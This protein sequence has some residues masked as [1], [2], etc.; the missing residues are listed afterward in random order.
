ME[1]ARSNYLGK[2]ISGMGSNQ[3]K[4]ITGIR[5]CGK[6]YLLNTIFKRHLLEIG[7]PEDHIMQMDFDGFRNKAYRNP[8]RFLAFV[9]ERVS[10]S[11]KYYLLLDEVQLLDDFAEVLNDL[12]RMDSV[13][14]YVT[15]SNA[16]LL[17]K[18][19]VTEFR[20]RGM[21]IPLRPLSFSEFMEGYDG[22]RRDGYDEYSMY[23]GLP[24]VAKLTDTKAKADYL[25]GIYDETYIRDIVERNDLRSAGDLS[26]VVDVLCSNIGCITNPTK[27]SN[28][29]KSEKKSPLSRPTIDAY[30]GYL[31]D[32]FLFE[33]AMRYDVKGRKYIGAGAK[34]Y[35]TDLGLRNARMNFRQYEE[36]HVLENVIYNELRGRDFGV[37]VGVVPVRRRDAEGKVKRVSYEIDF[38]CNSGSRR[39]YVQ[40][41]FSLPTEEKLAQEQASLLQAGDFFKRIIVTKEGPAPHYNENGVLMLNVY[42]FLLKPEAMEL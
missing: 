8:S 32:A 30:I 9:D 42:D 2:L 38:V 6:S 40:S 21:E 28:T 10:G 36:T 15:G 19:V 11:G 29:F 3:I 22:D 16:R 34:Y 26:D 18:D 37:D 39:C 12:I 20:G 13:D 5:R 14:V 7:I 17:S 23:G 35:A 4:V 31:E 24:T 1:Y 25:A 33:K 27:I 41:A